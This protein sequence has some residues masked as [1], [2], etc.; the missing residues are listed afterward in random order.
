MV[1][2]GAWQRLP[3]TAVEPIWQDVTTDF[4]ELRE[5]LQELN[6]LCP[7]LAQVVRLRYINEL[8]NNQVAEQL[9]MSL[10]TVTR[11]SRYGTRVP[12]VHD[13][14]GENNTEPGPV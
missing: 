8:N 11:D 2:G 5:A 9:G 1:H 7:R 10:K 4:L 12:E 3:L 6:S 13:Y 14:H